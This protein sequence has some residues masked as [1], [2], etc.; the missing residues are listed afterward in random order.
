M[1]QKDISVSLNYYQRR[2][3]NLKAFSPNYQQNIIRIFATLKYESYE[4]NS[5][6]LFCIRNNR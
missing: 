4:K 5:S 2:N 1:T 6:F 3:R